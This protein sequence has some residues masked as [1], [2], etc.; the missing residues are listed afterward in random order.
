MP[1]LLMAA[2][3]LFTATAGTAV[4]KQ[5]GIPNVYYMAIHLGTGKC[6]MLTSVPN[7]AKHKVMGAYKT[8]GAASRAMRRTAEGHAEQLGSC[9]KTAGVR[10][11]KRTPL[12]I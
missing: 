12:A 4:A 5:E 10:F 1:K 7:P 6:V 3:V 8:P 9:G 11:G 2:A